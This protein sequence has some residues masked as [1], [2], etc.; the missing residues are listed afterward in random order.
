VRTTLPRPEYPRPQLRRGRWA[1]LNGTWSFAF[2]DNDSGR[3][4]GWQHLRTLG[5]RSILVPFCPQSSL[6]GVGDPSFHDVV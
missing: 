1:N 5:P 3:V 4:R 6:S 2:D